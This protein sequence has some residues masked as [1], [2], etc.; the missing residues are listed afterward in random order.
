MN[1]LTAQ[2]LL[3][4]IELKQNRAVRNLY[5]Y[6]YSITTNLNTLCLYTKTKIDNINRILT[7]NIKIHGII[8]K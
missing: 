8:H 1:Q 4:K 6:N 5:N 3:N 7:V 2:E